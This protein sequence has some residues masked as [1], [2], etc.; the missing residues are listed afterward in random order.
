MPAPTRRTHR[1]QKVCP[2]MHAAASTTRPPPPRK[3][4]MVYP[5][6]GQNGGTQNKQRYEVRAKGATHNQGE[7]QQTQTYVTCRATLRNERGESTM[8]KVH[9]ETCQRAHPRT[10]AYI[11]SKRERKVC[12]YVH[13]A[14]G[15]T[16]PPPPG[17]NKMVW[18]DTKKARMKR[19]THDRNDTQ[20]RVRTTHAYTKTQKANM[21]CN[22]K[23]TTP[24]AQNHAN[25]VSQDMKPGTQAYPC[26]PA[27]IGRKGYAAAHIAS[28]RPG[29]SHTPPPRTQ[30][31]YMQRTKAPEGVQPRAMPAPAKCAERYAHTHTG[32]P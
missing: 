9:S 26:M 22:E 29:G 10:P 31:C 4:K 8:R 2:Y 21:P 17:K 20:P 25:Q 7:A 32:D 3:S 15:A 13:A 24:K 30:V 23:S 1:V 11:G 27:C 28:S 6:K 18:R 12:P 19:R 16:G 14:A 5:M